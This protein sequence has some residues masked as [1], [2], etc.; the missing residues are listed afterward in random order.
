MRGESGLSISRSLEAAVRVICRVC[1]VIQEVGEHIVKENLMPLLM[2]HFVT[3]PFETRKV[4]TYKY[5]IH[6]LHVFAVILFRYSHAVL[7][8]LTTLQD[9][10]SI[11]NNLCR[12]N[13]AGE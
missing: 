7:E 5:H 4:L 3:L 10:A 2:E 9:A 6:I 11:F 12:H 13:Y 1:L 8:P